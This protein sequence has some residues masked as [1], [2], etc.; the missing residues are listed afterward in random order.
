M[1]EPLI[2][3]WSSEGLVAICHFPWLAVCPFVGGRARC[4][5][6]RRV[7]SCGCC[8]PSVPVPQACVPLF[9]VLALFR[10]RGFLYVSGGLVLCVPPVAWLFVCQVGSGGGGGGCWGLSL[11]VSLSCWSGST[12][13]V[14]MSRSL[15]AHGLISCLVGE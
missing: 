6:L 1:C 4:C 2:K 13:C 15:A 14:L 5:C 10:S 8:V 12:G 3:M 7:V 11:G 9:I